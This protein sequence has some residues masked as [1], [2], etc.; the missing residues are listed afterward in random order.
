MFVKEKKMSREESVKVFQF[1]TRYL[2]EPNRNHGLTLVENKY[3]LTLGTRAT[4]PHAQSTIA[5]YTAV[6][7]VR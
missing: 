4:V 5:L 1:A 2:V 7:R 3:Q 6:C